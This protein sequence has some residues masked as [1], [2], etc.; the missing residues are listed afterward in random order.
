MT[1]KENKRESYVRF[2]V[3]DIAVTI[4]DEKDEKLQDVVTLAKTEFYELVGF[5]EEKR[6]RPKTP[7]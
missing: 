3:G 4:S 6:G 1:D 5:V 7:L 2:Q